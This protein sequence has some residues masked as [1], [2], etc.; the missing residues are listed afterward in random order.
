MTDTSMTTAS[1]MQDA[2]SGHGKTTIADG[3]V[4]KVAGIAAGGVNGVYALGGGAARA[5]GALRNLTGNQSQSQGITVEV[6]EK[7]AA[8]DVVLVADYPRPLQQLAD[9][10]RN[11]VIEAVETIVGLEVAEVN[12]TINDVHMPE[13]DSDDDSQSRVQ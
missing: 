9:S 8:V 12:V 3:V 6:G 7:Q 13:D 4:A 5:V 1:H 10:V 11:A 2:D